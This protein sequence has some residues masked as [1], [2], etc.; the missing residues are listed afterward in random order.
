MWSV[1]LGWS[2][3]WAESHHFAPYA[4]MA[5]LTLVTY[6]LSLQLR[7]KVNEDDPDELDDGTGRRRPQ[8]GGERHQPSHVVALE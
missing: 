3:G 2:D 1:S 5:V 7:S 4:V 8:R 6:A